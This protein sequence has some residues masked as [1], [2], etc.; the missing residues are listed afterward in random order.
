MDDDKK[1]QQLQYYSQRNLPIFPLY[2]MS[3]DECS[4]G[5]KDCRSQGKHPLVCDGFKSATTDISKILRWHEKWPHANWGIRTGDAVNGGS[6]LLVVDIDQNSGGF[7]NW[8]MLRSEHPGELIETVTVETGGGGVHLWFVYPS[9]TNI[10]SGAG[11]LGPGIDIRADGGYV[12]VPPSQTR[13]FYKFDLNPIETPI[14]H[15]P[16]WLLSL[17]NGSS[18]SSRTQT[19]GITRKDAQVSQGERHQALSKLGGSMRRLGMIED[20]ILAALLAIRDKR[21]AHGD[22]PVSDD[23]VAK[24]AEWVANKSRDYA[25]TDLG[26]AERFIDQHGDDVLYCL[27]L[28]KWLT[29]DWQ[30]WSPD[31]TEEI[32]RRGHQTVRNIS[33]E[34]D[35]TMGEEQKEAILKHAMRSEALGRVKNMINSARAYVPVLPED[36]DQESMLLNCTNGIVDLNTGDLLTHT[37]ERLMTKM[38]KVKYDPKAECKE[39]EKFLDLVTGGDKKLQYSL[40]LAIGYSLTGSTDEHLFFFLYG[41]GANGKTTFTETIRRLMGDYSHRTD[42]EALLQSWRHGQEATPHLADLAGARFVLASELPENRKLNESLIKEITGGDSITARYLYGQ[43]FSF[44]PTHKLWVFGNHKPNISG[45]DEGIWRRMRGIFPFKVTIPENQRRP[46]SEILR[47][48]ESEFS[49]ILNWAVTGCLMW[50]SNGLEFAPAMKDAAEEYRTEQD[51]VQQFIE[52]RCDMHSEYSE[53]K[54]SLYKAWR[55][56]CEDSGEENARRRSKHWL[57]RQMTNRG[58]DHYGDSK[59]MLQGL[60]L[61]H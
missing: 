59:K 55:D 38:I 47:I 46:M 25:L 30:R 33:L 22:H 32:V 3:G 28:V 21:F 49:G 10:R 26:N 14:A 17:L 61:R 31:R 48:F 5:K 43:P 27:E 16:D 23:E 6:G 19:N 18:E 57:T 34:V 40:Q 4:C 8:E 42:I 29:W 15:P 13:K 7:E 35:N 36:L 37:R 11:V 24:V 60:K 54:D 56:W 12:V 52:E 39:W 41:L 2:W 53:M 9:G 1:L 58:F 44:Q 20:E 51:L 45:T 50:Q